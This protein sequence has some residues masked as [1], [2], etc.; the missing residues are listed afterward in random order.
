MSAI[1]LGKQKHLLAHVALFLVEDE[2]STSERSSWSAFERLST[3]FQ[4]GQRRCHS[5]HRSKLNCPDWWRVHET[6]ARP[7]DRW[8]SDVDELLVDGRSVVRDIQQRVQ[9]RSVREWPWTM[10]RLGSGTDNWTRRE[11]N[12]EYPVERQ[13]KE[14]DAPFSTNIEHIEHRCQIALI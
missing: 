2:V 11:N 4:R 13:R 3:T 5:P 10:L 12:A 8:A 6:S 7:S 14:R 1:M 9:S